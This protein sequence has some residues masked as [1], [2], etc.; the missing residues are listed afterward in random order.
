MLLFATTVFSGC[1]PPT[2]ATIAAELRDDFAT[3]DADSDARL[4]LA[5]AQAANTDLTEAQFNSIDT[6]DDGFLS[7]A[8]L[9]GSS[10]E[11]SNIFVFIEESQAI[12]TCHLLRRIR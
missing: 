7:L 4:S 12:N 3:A 9:E 11:R 2:L 1:Q 5:E 8:E 10:I 6:D